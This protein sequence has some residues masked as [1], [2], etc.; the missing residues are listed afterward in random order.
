[1]ASKLVRKPSR[2]LELELKLK[3]LQIQEK[4]KELEQFGKK[5]ANESKETVLRQIDTL[6]DLLT[7]F[8]LDESSA[9][10]N[11]AMNVWHETE[12]GRIMDKIMELV[13]TI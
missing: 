8:I 10:D 5:L 13:E 3:E 7:T 11:K 12:Q 4:Q 1:M 2:K 6:R 9:I